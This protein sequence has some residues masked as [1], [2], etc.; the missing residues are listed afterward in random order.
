MQTITVNAR[1][2]F[3]R[4]PGNT[5]H[6]V[7]VYVDGEHIGTVPFEYG[8]DRAY[9]QTAVEMLD[10]FGLLPDRDARTEPLWRYCRERGI[11]LVED[12]ADVAR[13]KDLHMSGREG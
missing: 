10:R 9:M 7:A 12:V 13:R 2:W 8:Y 11:N 4:G 3:H 5:Y 1:R 6:S